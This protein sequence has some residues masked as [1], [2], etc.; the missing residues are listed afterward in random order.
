MIKIRAKFHIPP[1]SMQIDIASREI[2]INGR[3]DSLHGRPENIN[4][5]DDCWWRGLRTIHFGWV[6]KKDS[7]YLL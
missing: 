2:A 6:R 5:A 1:L 7:P 3:T 4:L